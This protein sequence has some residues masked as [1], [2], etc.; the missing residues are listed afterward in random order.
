[1]EDVYFDELFEFLDKIRKRKADTYM[2]QLAIAQNP[3][4]EDDEER[5]ALWDRLQEMFEGKVDSGIEKQAELDI[6]GMERMK[7][8]MS[9]NPRIIV[10]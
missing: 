4:I 1:M 9:G 3:H 8:A 7:F 2:I 5:R 10:K 6:A